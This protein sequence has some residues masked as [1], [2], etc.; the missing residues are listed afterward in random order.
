VSGDR[1]DPHPALRRLRQL[2]P[3]NVTPMQALAELEALARLAGEEG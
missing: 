3:L 2:D 1:R